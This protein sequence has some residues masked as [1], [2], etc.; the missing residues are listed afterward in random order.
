M[1]K[2]W[3]V[4]GATGHVGTILVSVLQQRGEHVRI[5]VR[6]GSSVADHSNIEV[7]EGDIRKRESLI[8]FL[9]AGNTTMF[10]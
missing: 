8:P 5:L 6:P 2:L 3:L 7:C 4:T 9:T 1:K 10:L